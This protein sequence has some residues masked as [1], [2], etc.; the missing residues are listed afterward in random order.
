[1]NRRVCMRL[2][3]TLA[4]V[5]VASVSAAQFG[6]RRW[7]EPVRPGWQLHRR[8]PLLPDFFP[9]SGRRRRRRLGCRY[10]PVGREFVV[11]TGGADQDADQLRPERPDQAHHHP[12]DRSRALSLPV[13]HDDRARRRVSRCRRRPPRCA[14]I[15]RRAGSCGRT[16]SG[17]SGP[18]TSG[19]ARLAKALPPAQYPIVDLPLEHEL[20]HAL[21]D[22]KEA[23]S[24]SVDWL[25]GGHRRRDVGAARQ[26]RRARAGDLRRPS[27]HHG[28]DDA[29]HRLRRCV[30]ARNRRP[31]LFPGVC[32]Q[33][34]CLCASTR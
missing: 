15:C 17:A 34:L 9:E 28:A 30:R 13:H 22:V 20:F 16:T 26:P 11:S 31:R 25:L 6:Q 21:Y 24:D 27:A 23:A 1:M 4:V 32:G 33:G 8:V 3:G 18:G 10:R 5:L 19:P 12:A 7:P 14:T 2:A 29:Q